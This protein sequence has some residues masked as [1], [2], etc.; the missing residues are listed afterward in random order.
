M[1]RV[2]SGMLA[3]ATQK[4]LASLAVWSPNRLHRLNTEDDGKRGLGQSLAH[5]LTGKGVK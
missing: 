5:D 3:P 1:M 4:R 2:L